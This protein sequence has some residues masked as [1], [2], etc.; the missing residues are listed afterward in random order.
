MIFFVYLIDCGPII[1]ANLRSSTASRT[2]LAYYFVTLMASQRRSRTINKAAASGYL[3][4]HGDDVVRS[5]TD[6]AGGFDEGCGSGGGLAVHHAFEDGATPGSR[7]GSSLILTLESE[8]ESD[9]AGE[10]VVFVPPRGMR[11]L[12]LGRSM[13]QL[14]CRLRGTAGPSGDRFSPVT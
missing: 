3:W 11:H 1:L 5:A 6:D 9:V 10:F 12:Y 13:R 7:A 14:E 2:Q 4:A 8:G